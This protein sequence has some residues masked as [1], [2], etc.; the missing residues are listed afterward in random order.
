MKATIK[1]D[2]KLSKE[3]DNLRR[4]VAEATAGMVAEEFTKLLFNA[5]QYS[6][7]YVANFAVQAGGRTGSKSVVFPTDITPQQAVERGS[8]P[9]ISVARRNNS[10][11][12]QNITKFISKRA[13]FFP[14]ITIYNREDYATTVEAYLEGQLRPINRP[15][16][17]ALAKAEINLTARFAKRVVVG[18]PEFERLRRVS[19]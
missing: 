10:N 16:A 11:L 8:L 4:D 19:I 2:L 14:E 7:N 3:I 12:K 15:G 17:H 5:P 1:T 9:A 18:S 13:G 6:G